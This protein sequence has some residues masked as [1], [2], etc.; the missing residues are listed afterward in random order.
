MRLCRIP[1]YFFGNRM[2]AIHPSRSKCISTLS[3]EAFLDER[4]AGFLTREKAAKDTILA[5]DAF[6]MFFFF[7]RKK[8]HF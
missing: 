4:I 5:A 1:T 2:V 6:S 3:A 7:T 8:C